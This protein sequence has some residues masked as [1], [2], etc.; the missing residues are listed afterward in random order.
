MSKTE[1]I[2]DAE[3]PSLWEAYRVINIRFQIDF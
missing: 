2:I 1:V 3:L